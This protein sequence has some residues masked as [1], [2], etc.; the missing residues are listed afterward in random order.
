MDSNDNGIIN[1]IRREGNV[2]EYENPFSQFARRT[3]QTTRL[4]D[5][6]IQ[7]LFKGETVL[8]VDHHDFGRNYESNKYL[9][10]K[11][12]NR[13]CLEH[14]WMRNSIVG[15]IKTLTIRLDLSQESPFPKEKI[16]DRM[17]ELNNTIDIKAND[18]THQKEIG[19]TQAK[20][21]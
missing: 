18:G 5:A 9:Y 20:L 4:V 16:Q 7:S 1:R 6:Y 12:V 10:N 14:P 13:L 21:L 15:N 19:T 8:V 17:D 3:G 11:I 2:Q